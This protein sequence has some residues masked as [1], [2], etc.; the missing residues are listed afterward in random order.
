MSKVSAEAFTKLL[1][2]VEQDKIVQIE[3]MFNGF[4]VTV[5]EDRGP[6]ASHSHYNGQTLEETILKIKE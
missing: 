1:S 5:F 4:E 3:K 6:R 2:L